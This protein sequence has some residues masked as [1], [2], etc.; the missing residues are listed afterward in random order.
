M[1]VFLLN[2]VMQLKLGFSPL[3]IVLT[4]RSFCRK[5]A[6]PFAL[7]VVSH[8]VNA[9]KRV[10]FLFRK[11]IALLYNLKTASKLFVM[12]FFQIHISIT[13]LVSN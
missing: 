7:R 4:K 12:F 1:S 11:N 8:D 10:F 6:F 2:G 5:V 3:R 13:C 9:K